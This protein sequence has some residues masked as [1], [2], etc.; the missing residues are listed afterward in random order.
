VLKRLTKSL[1]GHRIALEHPLCRL[2]KPWPV[3][4]SLSGTQTQLGNGAGALSRPGE[5]S[6]SGRVA[7][8]STVDARAPESGCALVLRVSGALMGR[9]LRLRLSSL[10]LIRWQLPSAPSALQRSMSL[11]HI[12]M[13]F[14]AGRSAAFRM[15]HQVG[16]TS[17]IRGSSKDRHRR[18]DPGGG[19][20]FGLSSFFKVGLGAPPKHIRWHGAGIMAP[21]HSD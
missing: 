3:A 7:Q 5:S 19:T 1:V 8:R 10:L 18:A 16:V 12:T 15:S 14:P 13:R 11:F 17:A 21:R 4:S 6:L 9:A 20:P 2:I